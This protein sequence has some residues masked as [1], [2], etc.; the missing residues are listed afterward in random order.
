MEPHN[1]LAYVPA[2]CFP[3]VGAPTSCR[4]ARSFA[5]RLA[6]VFLD[7]GRLPREGRVASQPL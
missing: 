7:I 1:R 5:D 6:D 3:G 2:G 4:R